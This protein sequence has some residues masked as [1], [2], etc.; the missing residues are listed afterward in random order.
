MELF[1]QTAARCFSNVLFIVII[2]I[3]SSL[4]KHRKSNSSLRSG[5][6]CVLSNVQEIK[7]TTAPQH[8]G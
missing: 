8:E 2:G 3:S 5:V 7:P 1:Y 4:S 6:Y